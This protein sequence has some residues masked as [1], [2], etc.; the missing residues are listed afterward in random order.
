MSQKQQ[1]IEQVIEAWQA[2]Q[3]QAHWYNVL[4]IVSPIITSQISYLQLVHRPQ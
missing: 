3:Q 1:L 4:P 2:L